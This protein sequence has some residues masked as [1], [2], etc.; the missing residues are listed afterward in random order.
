MT[1]PATLALYASHGHLTD[2]GDDALLFDKLPG[3]L[4]LLC[5]AL[6]GVMIHESWV[7]PHGL[8]LDDFRDQRR[9]TLPVSSRLRQLR[10]LDRAP[11][12]D[13]RAAAL[14]AL[15]TC[16][17]FALMLCGLLRHHAVPARVRCGFATYLVPDFHEDHWVCEYWRAD[18]KRWAIADAQLDAL[19]CD[20]L[21]IAFDA[22]DVPPE[23]FIFAP[24]AWQMCREGL[25]D[26]GRFG[27]GAARG[28]WFLRVNLMRD[29]LA[30]G[31]REVSAWDTWREARP[32][33]RALGDDTL[34]LCDR[35]ARSGCLDPEGPEHRAFVTRI[36]ATIPAPPWLTNQA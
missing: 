16:R 10:S 21:K 22:T 13:A 34:A 8:T 1:S 2:P 28:L 5:R 11:L 27:H 20:R 35:L 14:R 26:S 29:L 6:Q 32:K 9:E 23:T 17:D 15:C 3:E 24:Q 12:W 25:A 4:P 30:R 31:K 33:D 18:E 19:H 7:G 36:E